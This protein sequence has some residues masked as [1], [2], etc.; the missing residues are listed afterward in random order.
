MKI[1]KKII[2]TLSAAVPTM[3]FAANGYLINNPLKG[4]TSIEQLVL[5]VIKIVEVLM[6]MATV[7]YLLLAGL[8]FVT[9][10][11]DPAKISKARSQLLWGMVGAALV[12]CARII[13]TTISGTVQGL[14]G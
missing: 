9:A 10:K 13:A 12:L 4:V 6:I 5:N 11:G 1:L 8:S 3:M 14:L 2:Y 7:I